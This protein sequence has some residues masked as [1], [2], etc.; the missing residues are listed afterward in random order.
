MLMKHRNETL[1]L[2]EGDIILLDSNEH[3]AMYPQGLV[4]YISVHLSHDKL[5]KQDVTAKNW[6]TL[7]GIEHIWPTI[8]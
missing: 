5:F 3:I 6:F 4:S 2:S 7:R 8:Q 1:F